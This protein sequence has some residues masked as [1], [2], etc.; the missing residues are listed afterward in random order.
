MYLIFTNFLEVISLFL[1]CSLISHV[2][3]ILFE[4]TICVNYV[5]TLII[6]FRI[7]LRSFLWDLEWEIIRKSLVKLWVVGVRTKVDELQ[8]F[9]WECPNFSQH[10][11]VRVVS[12]WEW[13]PEAC[14]EF[15]WVINKEFLCVQK[16]NR[17]TTLYLLSNECTHNRMYTTQRNAACLAC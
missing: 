12:F 11:F 13:I 14:N 8:K 1:G 6:S 9:V 5:R 16:C 10:I 2:I 7:L 15:K 3:S 17:Q 4:E